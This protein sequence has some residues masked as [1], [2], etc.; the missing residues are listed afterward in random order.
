METKIYLKK[1]LFD[2][3]ELFVN[4]NNDLNIVEIK[5]NDSKNIDVTLNFTSELQLYKLGFEIGI[6]ANEKKP[7]VFGNREPERWLKYVL[8]LNN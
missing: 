4:S 8:P 5:E 3:F 1:T 2:D 7:I 6:K